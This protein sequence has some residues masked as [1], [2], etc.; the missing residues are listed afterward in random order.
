MPSATKMVVGVLRPEQQEG[1]EQAGQQQADQHGQ[2]QRRPELAELEV[3]ADQRDDV[4]RDAEE[5]RLAE[6]HDAREAPAQIEADGEQRQD[7]HV[8]G[9][10]DEVGALGQREGNGPTPRPAPRPRPRAA[11][12]RA[13][14]RASCRSAGTGIASS[15]HPPDRLR[16]AFLRIDH[17]VA[18]D[19]VVT[20]LA[21]VDLALARCTCSSCS[22]SCP[23]PSRRRRPGPCSILALSIAAD[24]ASRA[25]S[26]LVALTAA[27]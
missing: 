5:Q 8:G 19:D 10:R 16:S 27:S 22:A 21:G 12:G 11:R 20:G 15:R 9:E 2:R 7:Q 6:A 17:L 14:P 25:R 3:A 26:P 13:R 23:A 1:R 24:T 4:A 18:L